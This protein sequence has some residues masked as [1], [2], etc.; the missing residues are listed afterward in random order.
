LTAT[1]DAGG[2]TTTVAPTYGFGAASHDHSQQNG[3]SINESI[4]QA[5]HRSSQL[6]KTAS[7]QAAKLSARTDRERILTSVRLTHGDTPTNARHDAQ[8]CPR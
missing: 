8:L 2:T 1:Q 5:I 6:R 7:S 3:V 4:R